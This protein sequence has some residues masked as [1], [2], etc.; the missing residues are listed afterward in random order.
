MKLSRNLA[1]AMTYCDYSGL[2]DEEV[3]LITNFPSFLVVDWHEG[4]NGI[5]A[6]CCLTRLWNTCVEIEIKPIEEN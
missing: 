2:S 5:N 6:K 4:G 1:I 3:K